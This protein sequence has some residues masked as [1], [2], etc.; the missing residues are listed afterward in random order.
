MREKGREVGRD[1]RLRV[2]QRGFPIENKRR[3]LVTNIMKTNRALK[4][5]ERDVDKV[6]S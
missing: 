2:K 5:C 1:R 3:L 4:S 6:T